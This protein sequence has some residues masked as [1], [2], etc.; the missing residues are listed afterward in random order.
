MVQIYQDFIPVGNGNRPGYAMTPLYVT[1][2]N[3]ANTSK[4][5]TQKVTR[6]MSN[7]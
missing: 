3:T 4:E 5:L 1:V 6:H 7:A 2:H